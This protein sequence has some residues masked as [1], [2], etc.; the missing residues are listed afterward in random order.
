MECHLKTKKF[1]KVAQLTQKIKESI[2]EIP[3][4]MIQ[5]SIDNFRS[6]VHACEKNSGGLILN[7]YYYNYRAKNSL[8]NDT[9][10]FII[11]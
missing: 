5:D 10:I 8:F 9:F 11:A 4:K 7:K 1:N 2:N 3:I 6:R